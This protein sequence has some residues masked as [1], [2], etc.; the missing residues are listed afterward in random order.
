MSLKTDIKDKEIL[1]LLQEDA[2]MTT[3]EIAFKM[4]LSATAVYERIKKLERSGVIQKY[5][6]IV[7]KTKIEREFMVLCHIK[8]IQHTKKNV[9]KF[10]REIM[11]LDEVVE[12]LHVSGEY[13]YILK[14]FVKNMKAYR[15]FLVNELTTLRGIGSTQSNFV[16]N[17][18]K[19]DTAIKF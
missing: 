15:S 3:K 17:E 2:K 16:V 11:K 19:N 13:D 1:R 10:E 7:D 14:I 6:A 4:E 12:C 9:T 5:V 18:L 8:L